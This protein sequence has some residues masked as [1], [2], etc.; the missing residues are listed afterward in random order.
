MAVAP[1]GV[2]GVPPNFDDTGSHGVTP[3][4]RLQPEDG[5]DYGQPAEVGGSLAINHANEVARAMREEM[6]ALRA[7]V[8]ANINAMKRD[9]DVKLPG[10]DFTGTFKTVGDKVINLEKETKDLKQ[11]NKDIKEKLQ[12]EETGTYNF[13]QMV[14]P[15]VYDLSLIHI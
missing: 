12:E 10:R 8:E 13:I 6:S 14:T 4:R 1:P 15:R 3:P 5:G 9:Y 7:A 11:E 2:D